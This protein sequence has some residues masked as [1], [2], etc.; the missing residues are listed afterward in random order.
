MPDHQEQAPDPN[1][2]SGGDPFPPGLAVRKIGPTDNDAVRALFIAAQASIQPEDADLET[3][4]ALKK[5]TDSCLMSDLARA[6]TYYKQP[7]KSMWL[8]ESQEKELAGMVAIDSDPETEDPR[9]ALLTRGARGLPPI[10]RGPQRG[11]ASP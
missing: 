7:G 8:L 1:S 10:Y 2:G 5:Y 9:T 3:R 4:I 11:T 6:S